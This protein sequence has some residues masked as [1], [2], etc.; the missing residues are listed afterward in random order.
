MAGN[1]RAVQLLLGHTKMDSTVKFLGAQLEDALALAEAIEILKTGPYS[2]TAQ[3]GPSSGQ[4]APH[5]NF[6][7]PDLRS[8]RKHC[9]G[10]TNSLRDQAVRRFSDRVR[11]G[12]RHKWQPDQLFFERSALTSLAFSMAM[13]L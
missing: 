12:M 3:F 5:C 4:A 9:G 6:T 11:R 1:L 7:K 8:E 10:P 2:R 13:A